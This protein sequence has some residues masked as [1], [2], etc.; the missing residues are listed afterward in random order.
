[1]LKSDTSHISVIDSLRG[2]AAMMVCL[3]HFV[4]TTTGYIQNEIVLFVFKYGQYGVH[5]FF[6]ISGIVI[7]LSMLDNDYSWRKFPKYIWKRFL[8]IE[9]PYLLSI[10]VYIAYVWFKHHILNLHDLSMPSMSN[11]ALHIGYFI[12]FFEGKYWFINTYW[13]L[14]VEFQYY[15]VLCLIFPLMT[16]K[17]KW[18]KHAICGLFLFS[19]LLLPKS[20]FLFGWTAIFM[21]GITY[22]FFKRKIFNIIETLIWFLLSSILVSY[23]FGYFEML[24][25]LGVVALIHLIP[26][27]KFKPTLFLGKISYSLYLLHGLSGG[28]VINLLSHVEALQPYKI[29]V[30]LL[31]VFIAVLSAFVFYLIIEK[32]SQK[33]SKNIHL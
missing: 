14:A 21:L 22:I 28:L 2:I 26:T 33:W 13:S 18:I 12:P 16:H 9:P 24:F 23:N 3:Y 19:C 30:I 4:C 31:G 6:V 7:P 17:E 15:L 25:C 27:F 1:M 32:P 8:R 5:L 10:L 11:I 20:S 29:L